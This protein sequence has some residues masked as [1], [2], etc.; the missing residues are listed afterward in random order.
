MTEAR[1]QQEIAYRKSLIIDAA[2]VIFFDKGFENSTMEDIAH[3]AGYSKG[4][5]YSYF[6]SKNEICFT[7]VNEYF[8]KIVD[9]IQAVS[10]EEVTGLKKLTLI[11][12]AFIGEYSQNSHFCSIYKT[13]KYHQGRCVDTHNELN[14]NSSY[15]SRIRKL[16]TGIVQSGISDGSIKGAVNVAELSKAFWNENN[17]FLAETMFTDVN[18]YNYLFDL[19]IDSIRTQEVNR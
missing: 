11:R 1:K 8:S 13:F 3:K 15:S 16:I 5:L 4:S 7:I 2:R 12:D 17:C 18:A 6:N 19:I 10:I 14:I 9:L